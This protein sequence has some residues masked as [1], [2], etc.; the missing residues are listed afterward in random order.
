MTKRQLAICALI[1]ATVIWA[2]APPIFKW[3]MQDIPP[4]TLAFLRFLFASLIL[5]PFVLT[6]IRIK[7][8]DIY[9]LMLLAVTGL[10]INI[11]FFYIGLQI[12]PSIDVAIISTASPIFLITVSILFLNE[13]P[14]RKVLFGTLVSLVGVLLIVLRPFFEHGMSISVLGDI[15]YI[16]STLGIL[17]YTFLIKKFDLPYSS[18][19]IVFWTFVFSSFM[20]FPMFYFEM[21]TIHPLQHLNYQAWVGIGYGTI[22]SSILAYFFYGF[23]IKYIKVSEIG[24]F[25]YLDPFVT[26]LVAIPLLGEMI[27]FSYLLGAFFVFLGIFVAEGRLHYHPFH[28]LARKAIK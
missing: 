15:Y 23:G 9:K 22:F 17:M 16:I 13:H 26:A 5:F 4:F 24:I 18:L 11:G 2:A 14:R 27:T 8:G 25:T 3:S 1:G 6:K 10:L 7:F 19:T 12:A 28:L 20:F 21:I